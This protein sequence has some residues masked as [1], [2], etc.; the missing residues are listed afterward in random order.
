[1]VTSITKLSRCLSPTRVEKDETS[2]D[3]WPALTLDSLVLRFHSTS[4][5]EDISSSLWPS[6][7]S[8]SHLSSVRIPNLNEEISQR[9]RKTEIPSLEIVPRF[10]I[11]TPV[12]LWWERGS[13]LNAFSASYT[14]LSASLPFIERESLS[15]YA[16]NAT[17]MPSKRGPAAGGGTAMLFRFFLVSLARV[18]SQSSTCKWCVIWDW[19]DKVRSAW[20]TEEA[21]VATTDPGMDTVLVE[22]LGVPGIWLPLFDG[23]L[24]SEMIVKGVPGRG[25]IFP[26]SNEGV[27]A[28]SVANEPGWSVRFPES[29]EREWISLQTEE[30]TY[31]TEFSKTLLVLRN[32]TRW[33]QHNLHNFPPIPCDH[34]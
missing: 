7:F 30:D 31:P 32:L 20:K 23:I 11:T 33:Q 26:G 8:V 3:F 19:S 12:G 9:L 25:V 17:V 2:R 13:L 6:Y 29:R 28:S 22:L 16:P 14:N 18:A 1:M 27:G 24:W 4:L 10:P 21:L 15:M 34:S 5:M